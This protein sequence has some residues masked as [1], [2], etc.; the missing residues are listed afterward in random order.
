MPTHLSAGADLERVL[1]TAEDFLEWLDPEHSADLIDGEIFMHS[2]VSIRHAELLNFLDAILRIYIDEHQLGRL[3][4][5]EVAVRLSSRNVFQPDLAF[6]RAQREDRIHDNHVEG[7]PDLVVEALSP[8]TADRDVGVKFAEYEQH[9]VTEYWVLDPET[10]AHRCYR[11]DGEL[12]VEYAVGAARIESRA[13]P[14][15]FVLREWLD[16]EHTPSILASI[17]R[18]EA[19][20]AP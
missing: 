9:G 4:R 20:H 12:L 11:R 2:P 8:R 15:F 19:A 6:Y 5:E 3:F 14:G 18:I 10:L 13:V 1:L 7:A 17:A 16:P